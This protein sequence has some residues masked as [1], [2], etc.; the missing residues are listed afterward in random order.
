M[1]RRTREALPEHGNSQPPRPETVLGG[2][3]VAEF[4]ADYWQQRPLFVPSAWPQFDPPISADE[5][6]GLACEEGSSARIVREQGSS[7]WELRRGPFR[8]SEFTQLPPSHWT[9]LV[10]DVEKWLPELRGVL[11][12][13][14]FIPDWRIDDL[15][16]SYAAPL[17]SVGPH[18]DQYDVFLLQGMG[19]RRWQISTSPVGPDNRVA[20]SELHVLERF[21]AEQEWTAGPG[22][23]LY[24]PPGVAHFGVAVDEC[25]TFS[26]GSRAPSERELALGLL[27]HLATRIEPEARYRDPHLLPQ[28]SPGWI[29]DDA[30]DRAE[31]ILRRV[32]RLDRN[33]IQRWF[34]RFVTEPRAEL[35]ELL[36]DN[37]KRSLVELRAQLRRCGVIQR[38]SVARLAL[39][40][41]S[42][43][44]FLF[45][46]GDEFEL[47]PELAA[48]AEM[49]CERY[50]YT[51]DE[52]DPWLDDAVFAALIMSLYRSG[53]LCFADE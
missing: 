52:L 30:I 27:E 11:E 31:E 38:S 24:L 19:H 37:P 1:T 18:V 47:D 36:A 32:L 51:D 15:M 49:L 40:R 48:P 2:L 3:S 44:L 23:L 10:A 7:P 4:L 6:A 12:P 50:R 25:M 22:D 46:D 21:T 53:V 20:G 43:R 8:E 39:T 14:R 41:A 35:G 5:L 16:V 26:I 45:V 17:G 28:A 42:N 9:L 33:T 29:T 13:F 34:G